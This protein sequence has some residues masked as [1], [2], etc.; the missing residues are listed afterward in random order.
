MSDMFGVGA[1]A[2]AGVQAAGAV[3][4]QRQ[5]TSDT[6]HGR[7]FQERMANTA[8]QRTVRDLEAAGLNP[9]LAFGHVNVASAPSIQV[10]QRRN[11][12]E[13]MAGMASSSAKAFTKLKKEM[14]ILNNTAEI[15]K[16]QAAGSQFDKQSKYNEMLEKG[17]AAD[18]RARQASLTSATQAATEAG[19]FGTQIQNRLEATR[20]PAAESQARYDQTRMG[21]ITRA[22]N[23]VIRSVTGSDSTSAR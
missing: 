17:H 9:A 4:A 16:N 10:P 7:Q 8:F 5:A 11:V 14:E 19:T 22:V 12:M 2:G 13:G 18:L 15:T 20:I 3:A 21:E 6:R 23:R 1:L